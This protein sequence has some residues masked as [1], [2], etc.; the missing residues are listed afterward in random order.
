MEKSNKLA[1]ILDSTQLTQF[2]EC[3]YK[4]KLENIEH[5]EFNTAYK[6]AMIM[7]SFGHKLLEIYYKTAYADYTFRP[8][9]G[10]EAAMS[11]YVPAGFD[12]GILADFKAIIVDEKINLPSIKQRLPF[13]LDTDKIKIVKDR[14]NDYWNQQIARG[15]DFIPESAEHIEVG[16]SE[17]I[18]ETDDFVYILEGKLDGIGSL[19]GLSAVLDH[20]FQL[21]A[22]KI[23][24]KVIQFRNYSLV[25][26]KSAFIVNYIRLTKKFD[27]STLERDI[28]SFSAVEREIWKQ[29]LISM[30]DAVRDAIR[31]ETYEQRWSSCMGKYGYECD[32][33]K[34]CEQWDTQLIDQIKQT[35]YHI[36]QEWKP[37]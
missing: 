25:A 20:K 22:R 4:W 7:G 26:K 34:I 15:N 19:N 13:D 14:F 1:V 16:F 6:E 24:G 3:P 35:Y 32:F 31:S 27:D 23:Y 29:R 30:F 10:R 33:T 28:I 37:W 5:L 2:G 9:L 18:L 21:R 17:K 36:K 12:V 8:L 11:Y